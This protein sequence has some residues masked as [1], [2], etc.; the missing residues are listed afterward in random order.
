M[1]RITAILLCILAAFVICSCGKETVAGDTTDTVETETDAQRSEDIEENGKTVGKS[2]YDGDRLI[3]EE[4]FENESGVARTVTYGDDGASTETRTKE[5]KKLTETVK[6]STGEIVSSC[7]FD[8]NG[9]VKDTYEGKNL[10]LTESF[11]KDGKLVGKTSVK[12]DELGLRTE[13]DTVN[14]KG[15]LL[16]HTVYEYDAGKLKGFTMYDGAGNIHRYGLYDD[17]GHLNLYDANWNLIQSGAK[18]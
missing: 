18:K 16:Y 1:K 5:G 12:F 17:E 6:N 4:Y 8:D 2:Y 10:V 11:D 14:G 13:S 15:E 7:T 9:S 3:K